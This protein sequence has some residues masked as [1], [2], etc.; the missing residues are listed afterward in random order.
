[1]E[2]YM[3]VKVKGFLNGQI[4][5]LDEWDDD[6]NPKWQRYTEQLSR[7]VVQVNTHKPG[8]RYR[9]IWGEYYHG[10]TP[11]SN[12]TAYAQVRRFCGL[13]A[14]WTREALLKD[15]EQNRKTK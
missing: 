8:P 14:V 7:N 11:I 3:K 6:G 9:P 2:V 1:M 10:H 12:K 13:P 5:L 4:I 15:M